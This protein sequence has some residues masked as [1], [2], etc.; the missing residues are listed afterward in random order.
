MFSLFVLLE[1]RLGSWQLFVSERWAL[2]RWVVLAFSVC[3]ASLPLLFRTAEGFTFPWPT[4][5]GGLAAQRICAGF[6]HRP[7]RRRPGCLQ[8]AL[9]GPVPGG[10]GSGAA[11]VGLL[12]STEGFDQVLRGLQ[13]A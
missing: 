4:V 3:F 8:K 6:S 12:P 11:A 5:I 7:L 2:I 13:A 9:G 1:A 10:R